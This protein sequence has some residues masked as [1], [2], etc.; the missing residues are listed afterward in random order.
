M[1]IGEYAKSMGKECFLVAAGISGDDAPVQSMDCHMEQDGTL[2]FNIRFENTKKSKKLDYVC[3]TF[4]YPP[5]GSGF[6]DGAVLRDKVAFTLNDKT[7]AQV[8]TYLPVKEGKV[9]GT[10]LVI[11]EVTFEKSALEIV[12]NVKYHYAGKSKHWENTVAYNTAFEMLDSKG[13][14]IET[15]EGGG[16]YIEDE[17]NV[18]QSC[19][20]SLQELPETITFQARD[21]MEK[22]SFG[23]MEVKLAK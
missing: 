19:V 20:Y 22:K 17:I 21:V 8:M 11:D 23:T 4:V 14:I 10:D 3:E 16:G 6:S 1:T 12:C 5:A 18:T 2:L 13:N 15:S 7:N 9:P